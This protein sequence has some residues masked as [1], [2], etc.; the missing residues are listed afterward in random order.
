[1]NKFIATL[2]TALL[3]SSTSLGAMPV[4][5]DRL[6]YELKM[7]QR[8]LDAMTLANVMVC[9]ASVEGRIG[10]LAVANV[11][12]NRVNHPKFPSTI[13]EVV[14]QR[15]QF[16]CVTRGKSHGWE[17]KGFREAYQLAMDFIEGKTPRITN[18]THY[19][20]PKKMP[21]GASPFWAK[22]DAF[23][24]S[25]GNHKFYKLYP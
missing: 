13:E 23:L 5:Q 25:I 17:E 18:A 20:A 21:N 4:S 15:H 19:Y 3:L 10:M 2:L 1:M 7:G 24:G 12:M 16:E 8:V 9:E 22:E 11:V 6:D 14:N